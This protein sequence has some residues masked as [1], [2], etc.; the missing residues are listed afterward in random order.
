V[1][2]PKELK[3]I[4][5]QVLPG[6]RPPRRRVMDNLQVAWRNITDEREAALSRVKQLRRGVLTVE[7][8]SAPA[9]H[10]ISSK[11]KG[12][13]VRRLNELV[14]G[15]YVKEIRLRLSKEQ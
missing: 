3:D 15:V 12:Q 2:G 7:V 14:E 13:L 9:M 11:D 5:Q 4:L 8:D 1:T 6:L 10:Q